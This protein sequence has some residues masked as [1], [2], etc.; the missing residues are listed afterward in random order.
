MPAT[1]Y[2]ETAPPGLPEMPPEALAAVQSEIMSHDSGDPEFDTLPEQVIQE[3]FGGNS[4]WYFWYM[5]QMHRVPIN[6]Q[7]VTD[8][9][10]P[11][12]YRPRAS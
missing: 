4:N 9:P 1:T 5:A 7:P 6:G 10:A 3:K 8:I 2:A 12:A 11:E